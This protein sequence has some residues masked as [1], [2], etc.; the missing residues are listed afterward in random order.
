MGVSP[1]LPPGTSQELFIHCCV[2]QACWLAA[3]RDSPVAASHVCVRVL[4][5]RK[6]PALS[7]FWRLQVKTSHMYSK[8][9]TYQDFHLPG[10]LNLSFLR[11]TVLSAHARNG[12]DY[13]VWICVLI[14]FHLHF[15]WTQHFFSSQFNQRTS[16]GICI[17]HQAALCL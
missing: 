6:Q 16:N 15:V 2:C 9:L 8:Q 17:Q 14:R 3:S 5:L 1:C 10:P 11:I 4:A 7:G 12:F 13:L